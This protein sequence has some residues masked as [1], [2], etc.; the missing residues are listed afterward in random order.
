MADIDAIDEYALQD[1]AMKL[2]VE[3]S[4]MENQKTQLKYNLFKMERDKVK[5]EQ[6]IQDI[7]A[8]LEEKRQE[9]AKINF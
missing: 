4:N 7:D 6:S 2:E 3:I 1:A 5:F 8:A 9:R